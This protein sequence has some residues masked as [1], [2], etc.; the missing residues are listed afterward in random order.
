MDF[1]DSLNCGSKGYFREM[2]LV[3]DPVIPLPESGL[4]EFCAQ[5]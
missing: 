1:N 4:H 2:K 3:W 5:L